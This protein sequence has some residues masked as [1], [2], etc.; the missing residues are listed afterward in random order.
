VNAGQYEGLMKALNEIRDR[1]P[2][3]VAEPKTAWSRD[4]V[5]AAEPVVKPGTLTETASQ[6]TAA[7]LALYMV[8]VQLDGWIESSRSNHYESG[9]GHSSEPRGGECWTQFH[10]SDIRR[11]VNDAARELG[12]AEFPEPN[13]GREDVR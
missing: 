8:L 2:V 1:L 13:P 6:K 12:V 5:P 11:M 3:P 7:S 4:E 10:P 9:S